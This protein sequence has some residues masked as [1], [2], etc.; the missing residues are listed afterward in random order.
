MHLIGPEVYQLTV[1]PTDF[2]VTQESGASGFRA[3]AAAKGHKLYCVSLAS[4]LVYIGITRQRMS[5]RLRYG[6][7]ANGRSGYHGYAWRHKRATGH[8]QVWGLRSGCSGDP[9][10]LLETIEAEVVYLIRRSGQWPRFQTEIHFHQ[11][12]AAIRSTAL[13]VFEASKRAV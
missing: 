5:S 13:Q 12:N 1:S 9:D 10:R 8:L 11:S 4:A 6:W 7:T 3:L 2:H